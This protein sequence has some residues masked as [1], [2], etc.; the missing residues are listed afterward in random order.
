MT[1]LWMNAVFLSGRL[2]CC[3]QRELHNRLR[4]E[5]WNFDSS[6]VAL[7]GALGS[8]VALERIIGYIN[9]VQLLSDDVSNRPNNSSV[10][11]ESLLQLMHRFPP[12]LSRHISR[13]TG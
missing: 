12:L 4:L 7:N 8:G 3:H 2:R 1:N 10:S 13:L 9:V 5:D 6:H 11:S